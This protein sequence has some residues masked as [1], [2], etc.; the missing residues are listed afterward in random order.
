MESSIKKHRKPATPAKEHPSRLPHG[1]QSKVPD[2]AANKVSENS[3]PNVSRSSPMVDCSKSGSKSKK[4]V[5]A[6]TPNIPSQTLAALYSPRNKLKERK[7]VV[8]KKRDNKSRKDGDKKKNCDSGSGSSAA[9]AIHVA[10]ESLR[11]SQ[12]EFFKAGNDYCGGELDEGDIDVEEE[13]DPIA[14]GGRSGEEGKQGSSTVKRRRE[15]FLEEARKSVPECGKV[16]HLVKAFEQLL[17][18]PKAASKEQEEEEEEQKVIQWA[19]PGMQP[20]KKEGGETQE[21]ISLICPSDLFLNSENLGLD[22]RLSVSSSW[23]GSQGSRPSSGG[24]RSRRNS[25]ESCSTM[26]GNRLKKKKQPKVTNQKPFNLKTEQRG[27][28]KE[29]EFVKK[30]HEMM[31]EEEKQRIPVAQ[32][33]PWTTD[34]PEHLVKPPVKETTSPIDLMLHSDVRAA[35]RA[36]FDSQVAEK[37]TL[38]EEYKMERERLQKLAEEEELRRLKKELVPKAQPM[39]YFDRPFMPRR[40][41]KQPTVPKQPKFRLPHHKKIKSGSS[42]WNESANRSLSLSN[43]EHQ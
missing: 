19:L 5:A 14:D 3:D 42:S 36:E 34:E 43:N 27:K 41:M 23:D 16:M 40:S 30:V 4:P 13:E 20:S 29:E 2:T 26:G 33:L 32:G 22:S 17:T 8:A 7:F 28:M 11:A 9:S 35:E 1:F 37:L 15:K 18:V 38:I 31:T 39:P 10:Y 24:R 6:K 25:F 12:E 21:S